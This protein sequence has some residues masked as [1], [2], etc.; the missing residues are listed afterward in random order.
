M[1]AFMGAYVEAIRALERERNALHHARQAALLIRDQSPLKRRDWE[2]AAKRFH[3]HRSSLDP[4]IESCSCGA[5]QFVTPEQREFMFDYISV[6]PQFFRSGYIMERI[7][8]RAKRLCL[9]A[10]EKHVMQKLLLGRVREKA[11]RNF[12]DVCRLIPKIEDAGFRA[13][14]EELM[15]SPDAATRQRATYALKYFSE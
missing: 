12:R 1:V 3:A 9:S 11:F 13:E 6:D 8:R 5:Q 10:E 7:L 4:L 15:H 14:I 2:L